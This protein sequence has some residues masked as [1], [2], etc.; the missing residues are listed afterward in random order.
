MCLIHLLALGWKLL[1]IAAM[2]SALIAILRSA[3]DIFSGLSVADLL[4]EIS[5][6]KFKR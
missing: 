3:I 2:D 5:G 4:N 1:A 6:F